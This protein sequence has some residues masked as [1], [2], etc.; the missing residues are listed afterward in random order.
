MTDIEKTQQKVWYKKTWGIVLMLVLF[1]P[2]GIYLMWKYGKSWNSYIKIAVCIVFGIISISAIISPDKNIEVNNNSI[3][4]ESDIEP[5]HTYKK[6][7]E[8]ITQKVTEKITEPTTEKPTEKLTEMPTEPSTEKKTEPPTEAETEEEYYI[9][10]EQPKE[11]VDQDYNQEQEDEQN[12][13]EDDIVYQTI[14]YYT[15]TGSK[16]HYE[17]PCGRGTY[18]ECTLD[19]A[20]AKGLDP[21]GKCVL[22]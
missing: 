22:H 8:T 1:F 10:E 20:L 7:T 15:R 16:Y 14:V 19:E 3:V 2:V 21:C 5:T 4:L 17:N 11:V 9:Q 13:V 6:S 18:Y 12:E